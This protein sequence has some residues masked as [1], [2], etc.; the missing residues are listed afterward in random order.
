MK[1]VIFDF[2]G[3]LHLCPTAWKTIWQKLGY[4]TYADSEFTKFFMAFMEGEV[5][6]KEWCDLTA[7][8]FRKKSLKREMVEK[9]AKNTTL[10]PNVEK[11]FKRLKENGYEIFILSGSIK[12]V[13]EIALG[14]ATKCVSGIMASEFSYDKKGLFKGVQGTSYDYAGKARF[15]KEYIERT[16]STPE[17]VTFVGD[18]D[19]DEWVH[20]SGCNTICINP[21]KYTDHENRTK[22][23]QVLVTE[24]F[25]DILPLIENTNK[26][27]NQDEQSI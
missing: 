23:H 8:A 18:G 24:D 13:I 9:V 16:H 20:T 15:V 12:E 6:Y 4:S 3:T 5:S 14:D 27:E 26:N 10:L 22:W 25:A 1:T 21:K 7:K 11:V 2:D 19:N 17:D